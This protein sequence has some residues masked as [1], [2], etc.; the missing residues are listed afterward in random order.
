MG[1]FLCFYLCTFFKL[2]LQWN[3][4]LRHQF[5]M[6]G[7]RATGRIAKQPEDNM[8]LPTKDDRHQAIG[9]PGLFSQRLP[10]STN[11]VVVAD[12]AL[13]FN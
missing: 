6:Q 11:G 12:I 10:S 4:V 8:P 3:Q 2:C 9:R 5:L 7:G 1:T 13:S